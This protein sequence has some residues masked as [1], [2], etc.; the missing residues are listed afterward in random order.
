MEENINTRVSGQETAR[1]TLKT[2]DGNDTA[3]NGAKVKVKYKEIL[4]MTLKKGFR[5]NFIVKSSSDNTTLLPDIT[6][7]IDGVTTI[8]TNTQGEAEIYLSAGNHSYSASGTGFTTS[9]GSVD[10]A[11]GSTG[12]DVNI[13]MQIGSK[14]VVQVTPPDSGFIVVVEEK[15]FVLPSNGVYILGTDNKLY[16]KDQ[17]SQPNENAVGVAIIDSRHP[18]KGFVIVLSDYYSDIKWSQ[19]GTVVSGIVTTTS[20]DTAK[21]DYNGESNSSQIINRLGNDTAANGCRAYSYIGSKRGYLGSLGEWQMAYENKTEVDACLFKIGASGIKTGLEDKYWSSTQYNAYDSWYFNWKDGSVNNYIKDYSNHLRGFVS[22]LPTSLSKTYTT[23]DEGRVELDL[24]EGDYTLT[25]SKD[26]YQTY[27]QDLTITS[28]PQV[29]RVDMTANALNTLT[30]SLTNDSYSVS[31]SALQSRLSVGDELMVV[32]QK[33]D[34]TEVNE[35]LLLDPSTNTYST[36]NLTK[37][38]YTIA[39]SESDLAN[40]NIVCKD[41]QMYQKINAISID[42]DKEIELKCLQL[43]DFTSIVDDNDNNAVDGANVVLE[44]YCDNSSKTI[45]IEGTTNNEGKTIWSSNSENYSLPENKI[46][47]LKTKSA[48]TMSKVGFTTSTKTI[49]EKI[50]GDSQSLKIIFD[51]MITLRLQIKDKNNGFIDCEVETNKGLYKTNEDKVIEIPSLSIGEEIQINSIAPN[52]YE[53]Q[54]KKFI[55]ESEDNVYCNKT[56][57][58]IKKESVAINVFENIKSEDTLIKNIDLRFE[59]LEDG[60]VTTYSSTNEIKLKQGRYNLT[61]GKESGYIPSISEIE[62]TGNSNVFEYIVTKLYTMKVSF[63]N[64]VDGET[65]NYSLKNT[66][67]RYSESGSTNENSIQIKD[68]PYGS[69]YILS[70]EGNEG[71]KA[72]ETTVSMQKNQ[73]ISISLSRLFDISIDTMIEGC[74][75]LFVDS[76][77]KKTNDTT[78]VNGLVDINSVPFGEYSL[79]ITKEG[80]EPISEVGYLSAASL[81][82]SIMKPMVK[83]PKLIRI[84]K[85]V[86][87]ESI[88]INYKYVSLLMVSRGGNFVKSMNAGGMSGII[89]FKKNILTKDFVNYHIDS[90]KEENGILN[91]KFGSYRNGNYDISLPNAVDYIVEG[92]QIKPKVTRNNIVINPIDF[93]D[94]YGVNTGGGAKGNGGGTNG[95][96]QNP[97]QGGDGVCGARG[98]YNSYKMEYTANENEIIPIASIFGGTGIG[99]LGNAKIKLNNSEGVGGGA[100]AYGDG[101]TANSSTKAGYGAG[102][103]FNNEEGGDWIVCLYY[104]NELI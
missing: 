39:L 104:S 14:N 103:S 96:L 84:T 69:D 42:Q 75:V 85:E 100:G 68:I 12:Q 22:A 53:L 76:E 88:D 51:R 26:G 50:E 95:S 59:S 27:T 45:K 36:S 8:T 70:I 49:N 2:N 46:P 62:I 74:S 33:E 29:I 16:T 78:D 19:G 73:S 28:S 77:G 86:F 7:T 10:V 25:I 56:I 13:S 87:N 37:G 3:L 9:S 58:V 83:K 1:I 66:K 38:T 48:V 15:N 41:L 60:K 94:N 64:K 101:A 63:I 82:V 21:K 61:I 102:G 35:T 30:L 6:I 67:T 90:I 31:P 91:V 57:E 89:T 11:E 80:Y 97:S 40:K 99:G 47:Y 17:W 23:N 79:N 4:D 20:E 52:D 54:E 34:G 32:G 93:F 98:L 81:A 44:G 5:V 43:C 55:I 71:W 65:L 92:K 18:N 72:Y 24:P